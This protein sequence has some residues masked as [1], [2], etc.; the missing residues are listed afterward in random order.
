MND[1][2]IS[3]WNRRARTGLTE[4]ETKEIYDAERHHYSTDETFHYDEQDGQNDKH[5]NPDFKGANDEQAMARKYTR[6]QEVFDEME[7][8]IEEAID[9]LHDE[10]LA[11]ING[12]LGR[13]LEISTDLDRMDKCFDISYTI[14]LDDPI[15]TFRLYHAIM[16]QFPEESGWTVAFLP[17]MEEIHTDLAALKGQVVP[18]DQQR[19]NRRRARKL[20]SFIGEEE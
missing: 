3:F 4:K 17:T 8:R 10:L 6:H 2:M 18:F 9:K 20:P 12:V 14:I 16:E 7:S 5:E 19:T 13:N 1:V 11:L 15:S